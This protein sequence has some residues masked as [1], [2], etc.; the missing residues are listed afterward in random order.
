MVHPVIAAPEHKLYAG[1][2][3]TRGRWN[4]STGIMYVRGLY[5]E[6]KPSKTKENFI[7]W[8]TRGSYRVSRFADLF[9]RGE[10]LLAQSYEIN[11]GYPMPEATFTGGVNI[12]F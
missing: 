11:I 7:L 8:N 2:D 3:F 4:I 12:N 1:A 5:T 9:V 10:N 6:V